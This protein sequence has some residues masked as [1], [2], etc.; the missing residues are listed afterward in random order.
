MSKNQK[1]KSKIKKKM[2][3]LVRMAINKVTIQAYRHYDCAALRLSVKTRERLATCLS[4][5]CV[6]V[7]VSSFIAKY[8]YHKESFVRNLNFTM[9]V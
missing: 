2:N 9:T 6:A 8:F 3:K 7:S 4:G 5:R 1:V